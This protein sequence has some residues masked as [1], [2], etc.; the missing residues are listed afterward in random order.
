MREYQQA[1]GVHKPENTSMR[2]YQQAP[3][4]HEPKEHEDMKIRGHQ[5]VPGAHEPKDMRMRGCKDKNK[6]LEYMNLRI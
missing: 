2:G 3:R 6:Q 1:L 4:V 5:Q